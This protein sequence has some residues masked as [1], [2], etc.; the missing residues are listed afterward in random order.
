MDEPPLKEIVSKT[1]VDETFEACPCAFF[2]IPCAVN[3]F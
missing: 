2:K 1:K 3:W